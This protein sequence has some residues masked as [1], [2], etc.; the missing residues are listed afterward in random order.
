MCCS[1]WSRCR[2]PRLLHVRV[3]SSPRLHPL[4]SSGRQ[5]CCCSRQPCYWREGDRGT[6]PPSPR[7]SPSPSYLHHHGLLARELHP[8]AMK[9]SKLLV[10]GGPADAGD[11]VVGGAG[12]RQRLPLRPHQAR[13]VLGDN[14]GA[15]EVGGVGRGRN[16]G[17]LQQHLRAAL[18]RRPAWPAHHPHGDGV[19]ARNNG[20]NVHRHTDGL[21]L[22]KH[23]Q[24]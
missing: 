14:V 13:Q 20:K 4:G 9:T 3:Q 17:G 24:W 8:S 1:G 22:V 10:A 16:A 7:P 23:R 21:P 19:D 18:H 5:P 12:R 2:R 11:D 15:A 6:R